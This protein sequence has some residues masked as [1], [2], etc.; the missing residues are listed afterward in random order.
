[1][2]IAIKFLV[3]LCYLFSSIS[4]HIHWFKPST[5]E[6]KV[7]VQS[8][9]GP[10]IFL[11]VYSYRKKP[12]L[13]KLLQKCVAQVAKELARSRAFL[14]ISRDMLCSDWVTGFTF[15]LPINTFMPQ[16]ELTSLKNRQPRRLIQRN[17]QQTYSSK[18]M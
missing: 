3:I 9:N 17:P 11:L 6:T 5:N 14:N 8:S 4:S 12:I 10:V 18:C 1:M 2:S 16:N 15:I 13:N 7:R